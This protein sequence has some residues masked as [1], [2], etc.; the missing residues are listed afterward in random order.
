VT[1]ARAPAAAPGSP[2]A[3]PRCGAVIPPGARYCTACGA[4]LARPAA[5]TARA[6]GGAGVAFG[7]VAAVAAVFLAIAFTG[8]IA[9]ILIPNFLDALNKARQKRTVEESLAISAA[10]EAYYAAERSY[11]EAATAADLAATLVAAGAAEPGIATVDGWERPF[12]YACWRNGPLASGCDEYRLVSAGA[13]GEFEHED[14]ADYPGDP[15]DRYDFDR[16][17]VFGPG[18]LVQGAGGPY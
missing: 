1:A 6:G 7:V 15:T 17:L 4:G 13:D 10:L 14:P 18:G 12:R 8:I 11:P 2:A 16:D 9:A 3:C 5:A